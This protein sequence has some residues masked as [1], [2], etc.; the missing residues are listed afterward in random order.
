MGRGSFNSLLVITVQNPVFFGLDN[1]ALSS[2]V[3]VAA[4]AINNDWFTVLGY[5]DEQGNLEHSGGAHRITI[6][7]AQIVSI[8]H[9]A[10]FPEWFVNRVKKF[11]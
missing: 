5:F 4:A 1:V 7:P 9:N 6:E 8:H 11:F 3:L 10:T 2:R